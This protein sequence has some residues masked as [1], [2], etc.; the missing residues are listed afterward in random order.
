MPI[1]LG[2]II[3]TKG[4]RTP[5]AFRVQYWRTPSTTPAY[6]GLNSVEDLRRYL[7]HSHLSETTPDEVIAKLQSAPQVAVNTIECEEKIG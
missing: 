6:I 1:W 4:S 7:K 3:I 5:P 2:Q